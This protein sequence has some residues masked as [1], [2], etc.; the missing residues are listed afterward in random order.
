MLWQAPS[1]AGVFHVGVDVTCSCEGPFLDMSQSAMKT[2]TESSLQ[3]RTDSKG[4]WLPV[5]L[6]DTGICR[7]T[8]EHSLCA[9][10]HAHGYS[11]YKHPAKAQFTET[12][13]ASQ[14]TRLVHYSY[15]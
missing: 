3:G 6:Y 5:A 1:P 14:K 12:S 7:T 15:M 10:G 8:C 9:L 13:K 11:K 4:K 2:D